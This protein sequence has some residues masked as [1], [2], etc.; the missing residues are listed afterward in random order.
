ME[1]AQTA[2]AETAGVDAGKRPRRA[3]GGEAGASLWRL[4]R[5][6]NPASARRAWAPGSAN[7]CSHHHLHEHMQQFHPVTAKTRDGR[8]SHIP[9]A[10]GARGRAADPCG[11]EGAM[12]GGD[13]VWSR[14]L[15]GPRLPLPVPCAGCGSNT[16]LS[17][18]TR[19]GA[20]CTHIY[21]CAHVPHMRVPMCPHTHVRT[22]PCGGTGC[23]VPPSCPRRPCEGSLP[24]LQAPVSLWSTLLNALKLI[25]DNI[26]RWRLLRFCWIFF[27]FSKYI[28]PPPLFF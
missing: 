7:L 4:P 17:M 15:R 12:P 5:A 1:P 24:C 14:V 23:S 6:C 27:P 20:A 2:E 16:G 10:S 22:V 11:L 21:M 18:R 26:E 3:A 19:R 25:L 8:A 13:S 28:V 9:L